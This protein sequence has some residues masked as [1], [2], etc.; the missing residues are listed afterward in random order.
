MKGLSV[1]EQRDLILSIGVHRQERHLSPLEVAA[2]FQRAITAGST[3]KEIS[4]EVLLRD[5]TMITRLL[6]L[7]NLAPEI[8]HQVGWGT[9]SHISF[10]AASVIA[11]LT[12]P[13][14]QEFLANA[15]LE[16]QLSKNEVMQAVGIRNE[17]NR[18]VEQC[19][20]EVVRA[21]PTVIR[22]YLFIGAINSPELR[23]RLS[24]MSQKERDI[25][26]ARVIALNIPDLP[27]WEGSL[28]TMRF[29][30]IGNQDLDT[31]LGNLPGDFSAS[32]N[33]YLELSTE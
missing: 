9:K 28:G 7:L 3:I 14:E 18:P 29:T 12:T 22:R 25:L 2:L 11:C 4:E 21:R 19:V 13:S 23:S 33:R 26:F 10:S 8:R 31:A 1:E 17:L 6:R 20:E 5:T 30:L 32:I 27:H 15:T 24:G 16:H